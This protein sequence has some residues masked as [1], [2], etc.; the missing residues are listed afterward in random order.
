L[1]RRG[2]AVFGLESL[3]DL[4][5]APAEVAELA[6]RRAAARAERDFDASD[7][8]RDELATRGWEMRDEPGGGHTLVR[9]GT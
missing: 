8:L 2:L 6:V 5:E 7:R 9:R 4:D 1:L 3:G